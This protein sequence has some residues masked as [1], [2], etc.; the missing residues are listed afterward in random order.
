M[1][2]IEQRGKS[3]EDAVEQACAQ[4]GVTRD[5]V[6]VE[7]V[8]EQKGGLF[9]LLSPPSATVRVT[10]KEEPLQGSSVPLRDSGVP[11]ASEAV[12]IQEP[13]QPAAETPT[14]PSP[15]AEE[16]RALVQS[17]LDSM[18]ISATAT[19]LSLTEAS[20]AGGRQVIIDMVGDDSG[21]LIG[22]YGQ[23]LYA[24]QYLVNIILN[25]GNPH[26][27]KVLL[28]VQGYR[29]RREE[30]LKT[31]ARNAAARAKRQGR[32]V[33]LEPLPIHERRIIHLTLQDDKSV[34]TY[35]EGEDPN[36]YVIVAPSE[37]RGSGKPER[38][39]GGYGDR[40]ERGGRGRYG[41]R[42]E[43]GGFGGR[44]SERRFTSR[45][46]S[47]WDD[48]WAKLESETKPKESEEEQA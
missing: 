2:T 36:R 1:K 47:E 44:S 33:K 31:V 11:A 45:D 41:D 17:I 6:E 7:V 4:L 10:V 25:K 14:A 15:T 32:K 19:V 40:G 9:G 22:K 42:G 48:A 12:P 46:T 27:L 26:P 43:R 38:G 18:E 37:E 23:T 28:D 21:V 34:F 16:A 8:E 3:V 29:E 5:Q 20:E 39:R 30:S 35:S 13:A 24:L